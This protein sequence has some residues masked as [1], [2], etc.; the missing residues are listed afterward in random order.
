[1]YIDTHKEYRTLRSFVDLL[2]YRATY[3]ATKTVY[4]FLDD[5]E[6]ALIASNQPAQIDAALAASPDLAALELF[7]S[8]G[9]GGKA[10]WHPDVNSETVAFLQYTSDSTGQ[11]KG[12]MV[13]H[14][15][16]IRNHKMIQSGHRSDGD[17][18]F[19]TWLP[20]YH[21]MGLVGN[22]LHPF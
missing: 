3:S 2:L 10:W 16:V 11:P 22:T 13:S 20:M 19:V 15:N 4:T 9:I 18:N 1:M 5:G 14:G 6:A 8:D 7:C 21:D 17:S 12:V